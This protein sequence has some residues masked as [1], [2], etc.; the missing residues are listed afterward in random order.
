MDE[1]ST[2]RIERDIER[3]R[4]DMSETIEAL[5]RKLS[6]GELIDELWGR[7]RGGETGSNVADTIRDHPIPLA[8]MG[9]GL[10]W[11]A[12]EKATES[13]TDQLRARHGEYGP[14]TYE[15][16]EGRVGPYRGEELDGPGATDRI[17][18]AA[19]TMKDRV[20]DLAGDAKDRISSMG[21]AMRDRTS[22]TGHPTHDHAYGI[23]GGA[24]GS[25]GAHASGPGI[26]DRASDL[27]EGA[28]R[29]MHHARDAM[30]ERGRQMER[31]LQRM[32]EDYP[33]ALGA[34]TFGLGLAAGLSVPSTPAENRVMGDTAD[35]LKGEVKRTARETAEMAKDVAGE[36][37]RAAKSEADRQGMGDDLRAKAE[38]VIGAAKETARTESENR[39]LTADAMQNR[40]REIGEKTAET[41][42]E[43]REG[44]R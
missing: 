40:A 29:E 4:A 1:R 35:T 30:Q 13:R 22:S 19:G 12:I 11:L 26:R 28:E 33:L 14:G 24:G 2:D 32:L 25:E 17:R 5:E 20:A 37:A 43:T 27:R 10:G 34:V 41:A 8:M 21:D 31:G 44:E 42:R 38:R 16:A 39:G 23:G 3:T 6:P 36:A 18:D 7:M 15:R 9:L